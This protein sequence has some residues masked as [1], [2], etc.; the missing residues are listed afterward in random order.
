MKNAYL[1]RW[2]YGPPWIQRENES[3]PQGEEGQGG[4]PIL[5]FSLMSWPCWKVS[6]S[7]QAVGGSTEHRRGTFSFNGLPL[8]EKRPGSHADQPTFSQHHPLW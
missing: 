4:S 6:G 2:V 8:L 3:W 7:S 5:G 1:S